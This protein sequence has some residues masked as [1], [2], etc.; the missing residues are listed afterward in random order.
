[1]ITTTAEDEAPTNPNA[2]GEDD[3]PTRALDM[4]EHEVEYVSVV[5]HLLDAKLAPLYR[6]LGRIEVALVRA[7]LMAAE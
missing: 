7:G 5:G 3:F 2:V 6:A 1:M 4:S